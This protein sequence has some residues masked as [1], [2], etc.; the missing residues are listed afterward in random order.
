MRAHQPV[1]PCAGYKSWRSFSVNARLL[2]LMA[3]RR[4]RTQV[5]DD[6][7]GGED[8]QGVDLEPGE[9]LSCDRLPQ[10]ELGSP[11]IVGAVRVVGRGRDFDFLA[12]VAFLESGCGEDGQGHGHVEMDVSRDAGGSWFAAHGWGQLPPGEQQGA[13]QTRCLSS[14]PPAVM[15]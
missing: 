5:P 9:D 8:P 7:G 11:C 12:L 2:A 3:E 10:P 4:D 14:Y 1:K 15:P 6:G 13:G